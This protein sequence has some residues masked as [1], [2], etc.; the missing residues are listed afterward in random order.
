[1]A[2]ITMSGVED[3]E[4]TCPECNKIS[5]RHSVDGGLTSVFYGECAGAQL[6]ESGISAIE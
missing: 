1:M 4:H 3:Y 5:K 6:F 2:V